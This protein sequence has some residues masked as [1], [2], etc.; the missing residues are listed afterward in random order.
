MAFENT[1]V[2][3][4][5][6]LQIRTFRYFSIPKKLLYLFKLKSVSCNIYISVILR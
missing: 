5:L 1:I 4:L 6:C 3:C 2:K